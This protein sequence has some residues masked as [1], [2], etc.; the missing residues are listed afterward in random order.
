[1]Q[2]TI[3]FGT[4]NEPLSGTVPGG[5]LVSDDANGRTHDHDVKDQGARAEGLDLTGYE[6]P[7]D[8]ARAG[9]QKGLGP[10]PFELE[11]LAMSAGDKQQGAQLVLP[12]VPRGVPVSRQLVR[13]ICRLLD[14]D[15]VADVAELLASEVVTNAV[16]HA[17]TASVRVL[18]AVRRGQLMVSVADQDSNLPTMRWGDLDGLGGRGLHLL[19]SLADSWGVV[20]LPDGKAVWFTLSVPPT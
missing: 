2:R 20:E 4:A 11:P 9:V 19:D 8:L 12:A 10:A 7:S 5:G 13:E 14:L 15:R 6:Q 3:L 17:V 18:V 1:M 16:R